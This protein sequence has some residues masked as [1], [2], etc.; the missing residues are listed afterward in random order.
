MSHHNKSIVRKFY[1]TLASGDLDAADKVVASDYVNHSAIPGQAAGLQGFKEAVSS[2]RAVFPDL[3][4][5]IED[6]IAEGDKVA[7]RYTV[8]GTHQGEF[9]GVAATGKPVT[10]SALV[11]QRVVGGK[12]QESWLQWDQL[13]LLQQLGAVPSPGES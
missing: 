11:I 13:G 8:R 1:E 4:F 10:W 7:T 5:T 2:L 12:V 6:Q 9:M 3:Q